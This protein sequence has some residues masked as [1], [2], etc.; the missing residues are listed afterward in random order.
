MLKSELARKFLNLLLPALLVTIPAFGQEKSAVNKQATPSAP[1]ESEATAESSSDAD[2]DETRPSTSTSSKQPATAHF[3]L[4]P[5]LA[6]NAKS[7]HPAFEL[8]PA[9]KPARVPK[10]NEPF[11]KSGDAASNEDARP[12]KEADAGGADSAAELSKKL[13]N[14]VAS[15]ISFP[16][17]TNFDVGMGSGGSGWRMTM[18]IQP[19]IP[20]AL[21]PKWNLIS[22][23]IVPIIHQGDVVAPGTGQS[24]LGDIVQSFFISPNKSEPFIWGLGPVVLVPTATNEFLGNHQL[25]LGPTLVVLKQ[26]GPWTVGA[27]MNHLWRV[28]GGSGRPPVNAT[29]LQP[30]LSYSTK[31]GWSYT[32]NTESTYD[33]TGNAWSVPVHFNI[34]KIVRFGKQPISFGGALRCWVTSPTGGPE[35]CGLRIVVTGIFPKK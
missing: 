15:L 20:I 14:P 3:E 30:F 23:T 18:N 31:D 9:S 7:K 10:L 33:W 4:H 13:S 22:R 24:G 19:V 6:A 25:G 34:A 32:L 5:E 12:Q 2:A 26:R 1:A 35:S 21:N 27:L 8:F 11:N 28:A 17:Q 16:I 29:F